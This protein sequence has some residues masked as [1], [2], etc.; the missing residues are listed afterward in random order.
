MKCF[1]PL[2]RQRSVKFGFATAA[3]VV[4]LSICSTPAAII[5]I[6]PADSYARI[7]AAKPGDEVIIAPGIYTFRVYLTAKAP[8]SNP[9]NIHAQDPN[10][11]PVWD[12]AG[13]LVE[14]APGSYT[15]GDRGRGGWQISGGSSYHISGIVFANCHN[16]S[17]QSAG[18]RYYNGTTGLYV[19]DCVFRNNDNG[20][21]GGTQQSDATVEFCEFNSNGNVSATAPTHNIYI[22]GGTFALRYSYVHDSLQGQ[23]FHIRAQN[24]TLE[25][26]WFARAKS[27]EGDL[28]TDDDF[29]GSGPFTQTMLVRGNLFLQSTNPVNHS[30]VMVIYND[31]GLTNEN[32]S[33]DVINNTFV[34]YGGNSAFVHLSNADGTQMSARVSNNLISGTTRPTLIENTATATITGQNNWLAS[35][36]SPGPLSNSVFSA[37]PGFKNIASMDFTL[38]ANSAALGGAS[39]SVP[40]LPIKEYYRNE[41]IARQYRLRSTVKDIGAFEGTTSGT[42]IGPY[43]VPPAPPLSITRS[44][45]TL[46]ISWPRTAPDYVLD[47][48]TNLISANSWTQVPPPYVTNST[49]FQ[50]SLPAPA[51]RQF[52]RLRKP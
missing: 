45:S 49:N 31:T 22:Y 1:V 24:S 34:G 10:N 43:D 16:A 28:M 40:G 4:F 17:F 37:S 19:K 11:K 52:Y 51:S 7:E 47:Q 23:N 14:N 46:S 21:T 8:A 29:S 35:G 48:T 3:V 50:I 39:Q 33:M 36:A 20:I 42:G 38:L 30:Q 13:T 26:N 12:F 9:I 6:T 41:S 5:N 32:M 44:G 18:I 25:Y 27:Y 2:R 15:A